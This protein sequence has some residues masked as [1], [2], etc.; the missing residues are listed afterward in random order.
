MNNKITEKNENGFLLINKFI[1]EIKKY[2][3][4]AKINFKGC[5]IWRFDILAN[6]LLT[7]TKITFAYILWKA[8][9][10]EN[11]VIGGFTF[12]SMLT[13][14]VTG[15]FLSG[16]DMSKKISTEICTRVIS[17]TFSKYIIIPVNIQIYFM[18]QNFGRLI[19]YLLLNMISLFTWIFI[20]QISF[21]FTNNMYYLGT[22]AV[23][24]LL[25]LIFMTE[26]QFFIGILSF[27]FLE[28]S[29]FRIIVDNIMVFITGAAIPLSL[30]PEAVTA[31]MR[32][33]PFYYIIYLPSMLAIGRNGNEALSGLIIIF[34]WVLVFFIINNLLYKR[35]RVLF[36]G[37]GI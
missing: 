1:Y 12:Y 34:A 4:V 33:F 25:G 5:I 20:L 9:F 27:K 35:L 30:L 18:A 3:E 23:M 32:I 13:Y 15:A 21:S 28:I 11:D 29:M 22:A 7:V 17:G 8:V 26:F 31:V 14:Y 6:L 2:C 37:V 10:G 16:A 19:F 24:A 36:E